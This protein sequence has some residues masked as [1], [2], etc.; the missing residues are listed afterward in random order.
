MK[1]YEILMVA[2]YWLM[3]CIDH[4]VESLVAWFPFFQTRGEGEVDDAE[5]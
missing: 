1:S 4:K 5:R 3:V 2:S